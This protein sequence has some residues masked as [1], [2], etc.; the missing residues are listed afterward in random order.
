MATSYHQPYIFIGGV[1]SSHDELEPSGNVFT[2]QWTIG[3]TSMTGPESGRLDVEPG[4]ALLS[5]AEGFQQLLHAAALVDQG[6]S[7]GGISFQHFY[8]GGSING[9]QIVGSMG[10][11]H[12]SEWEYEGFH[13]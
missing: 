2:L 5:S 13:S 4:A 11:F 3:A 6:L 12:G 1:P 9:I 10:I 7:S 8:G